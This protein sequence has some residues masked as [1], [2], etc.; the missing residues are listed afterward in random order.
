MLDK[1]I[2][3]QLMKR[4]IG[5]AH[6]ATARGDYALGAL[7]YKDGHVIAESSSDL[8][9][10]VDPSAHPEMTVIRK[11]AEMLK[12]RYIP[13]GV[14][15]STLEPCPMCVA[16]AIWAKMDGIVFG[17]SQT[18]AGNWSAQNPGSKFSWRQINLR[19]AD[20]AAAGHPKLWVKGNILRD[21]CC[22]LFDIE[23]QK[24]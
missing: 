2:S 24:I 10:G 16:A 3:E 22:R 14:L 15:V 5:L 12:N 17:A 1:T 11:V 18:D 13:N 6:D 21:E 19:C 8:A 20:V 4:C 23:K 9:N 7:V